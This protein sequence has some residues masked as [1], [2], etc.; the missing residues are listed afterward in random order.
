MTDAATG[1]SLA[2]NKR[3]R[4]TAT[5]GVFNADGE[6]EKIVL[7]KGATVDLWAYYPYDPA[8]TDFSVPVDIADQSNQSRLDVLHGAVGGVG[9]FSTPSAFTFGRRMTRLVFNVTAGQGIS[10]L[11][12]LTATVSGVPTRA[13]FDAKSGT[14]SVEGGSVAP[15]EGKV[16]VSGTTALVEITML[17]DAQP[18]I[19]FTLAGHPFVWHAGRTLA[20][21]LRYTY[22]V[23]L[24]DKEGTVVP[25]NRYFDTPVLP[26]GA[27][28]GEKPSASLATKYL[29][30]P[31]TELI[32][33]EVNF[34]DRAGRNY[35]MLYDSKE[36]IAHWIAYP[37][38]SSIMSSGNRTDDWGYDPNIPSNVQVNLNSGWGGSGYD[39]GHQL[40][41]ADRNYSAT[42]NRTTFYYTNMTPQNSSLNQ[43]QWSQLEGG[44]GNTGVRKWAKQCDT[45]YVV[46]GAML[47]PAGERTYM[48]GK[49][50]PM[51]IPEYYF[52]ALARRDNNGTADPADD[53]YETVAFKVDNDD[54]GGAWSGW[55]IPVAELEAM[56]G[57][58]F[59]PQLPDPSIKETFNA[60]TWQ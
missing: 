50:L 54:T 59:F 27:V 7:P 19:S 40:P 26:D 21:G 23:T 57:Y 47:P 49:N 10:S 53:I 6:S 1:T 28:P 22:S 36:H 13:T 41:S 45:L 15:F 16:T 32:Y 31:G 29:T 39:R 8:A 4:T 58:T 17:P 34:P 30:F 51:A 38:Y 14:M 56:T 24:T 5:T 35:Q 42:M 55:R 2:A 37:M 18:T 11:A 20:E 46:T 48:S 9:S 33:Y 52:K 25:A 12:G 60:S 43:G 3:Y 44:S